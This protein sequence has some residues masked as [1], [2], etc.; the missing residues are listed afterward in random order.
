[1]KEF[2]KFEIAAIKRTAQNVDKYVSKKTKLVAKRAELDTE[3]QSLQT[4]IDGW[5]EP[6]K[7]MTGGFTTEDLIT[8]KIDKSGEN[9]ITKYELKYP[10]T[11]IPETSE[12]TAEEVAAPV[13]DEAPK[14]EA[15]EEATKTGFAE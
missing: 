5:Q 15:T 11:V 4:M 8:K 2:S 14:A 12:P 7:H 6:I 3:I 1:M 9:P 13:A 10:E